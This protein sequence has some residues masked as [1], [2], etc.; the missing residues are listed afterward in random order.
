MTATRLTASV[1]ALLALATLSQAAA[2]KLPPGAKI[3]KLEAR[4]AKITLANPFEYSQLVLTGVTAG[5][6]RLDV[7]RMAALSAGKHVKISP[8]GQVRPVADGGDA[9]TVVLD[10]QKLVIPVEVT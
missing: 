4:P 3:A 9:V 10:G 8:T 2:E 6:E 5:G 7:T 1:A